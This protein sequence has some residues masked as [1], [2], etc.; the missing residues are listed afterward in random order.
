[1]LHKDPKHKPI[2][3]E[4]RRAA[5]Y[6][7]AWERHYRYWK[8][9]QENWESLESLTEKWERETAKFWVILQGDVIDWTDNPL[10]AENKTITALSSMLEEGQYIEE[11]ETTEHKGFSI[12]EN[13]KNTKIYA[14]VRKRS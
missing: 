2:P 8:A 5:D 12:F 1:M 6:A 3:K 10:E 11:L 13:N 4:Y 14:W 9:P 7:S